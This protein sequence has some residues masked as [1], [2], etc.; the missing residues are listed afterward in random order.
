M[1][2]GG[3]ETWLMHV[4]R[5]ADPARLRMDFLVHTKEPGHY[6]QEILQLGGNVVRCTLPRWSPGYARQIERLLRQNGPYDVFHSHVHHFSG[7]LLQ[8]A[9]RSGIPVRIAHSHNDTSQVDR[10][11]GLLRRGYIR[12]A[13]AHIQDHATGLVGVSTQAADALFGTGWRSDVRAR[14][15]HCGIDLTPFQNQPDRQSMR[16]SLGVAPGEFLIGHIGRFELQKNHSFLV[17]V[18]AQIVRRRPDSRLLLIGEGPRRWFIEEAVR[19]LGISDRVIFAGV[20]GDI[21]PILAAMDV[22]MLPSLWEGLPL[23]LLEAEAAGLPCVVSDVVTH[24]ADVLM[25]LIRRVSLTRDEGYWADQVLSAAGLKTVP[26]RQALLRME[27][28]TFSISSSIEQLYALYN[29]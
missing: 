21:P 20:R 5:R 26:H 3:V 9:R 14:I 1:N 12:W 24:E 18:M 11:A 6:D 23:V 29:A 25:E 10:A 27:N 16:A 17:R 28:S 7:H 2:R 15:L 22:L 4:L 13:V 8:L 19:H